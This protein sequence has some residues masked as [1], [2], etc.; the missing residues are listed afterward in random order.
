[1]MEIKSLKMSENMSYA[2]C[3]EAILPAI[4][5]MIKSNA[6]EENA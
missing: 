6:K 2:D 3:V 5:D 4:F 1:M